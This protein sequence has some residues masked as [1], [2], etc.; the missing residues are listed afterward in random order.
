VGVSVPL[1]LAIATFGLSF[2]ANA[3]AAATVPGFTPIPKTVFVFFF[4]LTSV[5]AVVP[6]FCFVFLD[7][8]GLKTF[9]LGC[10]NTP[11]RSNLI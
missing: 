6:S 1:P 10:Q 11:G 7:F 9:I 8:F 3:A 5:G 4:F 2:L